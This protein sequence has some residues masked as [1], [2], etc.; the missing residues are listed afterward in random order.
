LQLLAELNDSDLE[1]D[2]VGGDWSSL[3]E[4]ELEIEEESRAGKRPRRKAATK[5]SMKKSKSEEE[6]EAPE[7]RRTRRKQPPTAAAPIREDLE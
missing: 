6:E 2:V 3:P 1:I 5:L 4:A 7:N